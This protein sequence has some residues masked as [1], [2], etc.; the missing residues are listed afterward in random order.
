M[1]KGQIFSTDFL[2]AM[3][4]I[5]LGFGILAGIA[6]TNQYNLKEKTLMENIK[7]KAQ[8]A[9]LTIANSSF[10]DCNL[11][12]TNLAYSIN[13]KKISALTEKEIKQKLG[14]QDYNAQITLK[15]TPDRNILANVMNTNNIYITT[16]KVLVCNETTLPTDILECAKNPGACNSAKAEK[17]TLEVKVGK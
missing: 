13:T 9:A 7:N 17:R 5:I 12:D 1:N 4:M 2:F 8:T 6:E 16:V 11:N 10:A 15:G 14:L 3:I